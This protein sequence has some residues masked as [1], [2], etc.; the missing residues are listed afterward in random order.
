MTNEI[1]T[2]EEIKARYDGDGQW[3]LLEDPEVDEYLHVLRGKVIS[4]SVDR[5]SMDREM[6]ALRPKHSARLCFKRTP[7]DMIYVL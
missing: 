4:H 5:D 2:Y 6:L 3:V 7:D 1:L